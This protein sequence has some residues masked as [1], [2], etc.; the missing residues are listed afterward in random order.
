MVTGNRVFKV[1]LGVEALVVVV[2]I[3][4][5]ITFGILSLPEL[6]S[7]V[8]F[9]PNR[10]MMSLITIWVLSGLGGVIGFYLLIDFIF[11][12]KPKSLK[13][14]K[15][16]LVLCSLGAIA[17]AIFGYTLRYEGGLFIWVAAVPIVVTIHFSSI[18]YRSFHEQR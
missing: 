15:V 6:V 4:F 3:V 9:G 1:L 18:A 7:G 13:S 17:I 2:P 12:E 8:V 5:L 11:I 16:A 10:L 14:V